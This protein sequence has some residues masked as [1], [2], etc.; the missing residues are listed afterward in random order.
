MQKLQIIRL[1]YVF[2]IPW[3]FALHVSASIESSFYLSFQRWRN[4]STK[5]WAEYKGHMPDLKEFS[6]CHWDKPSSFNDHINSV[7][8]YCFQ[9]FEMDNINCF[10][11]WISLIRSTANRHVKISAE[12]DY[13]S[14][15]LTTF[16]HVSFKAKTI[17]YTHRKWQHYCWLYSSVTGLNILYWNG[18]MVANQTVPAEKRC[19]WEGTKKGTKSAFIIGQEQDSIG[20]GFQ[21]T[22]VF[23]GDVAELN[24]WNYHL[25][26]TIIQTMAECKSLVRGNIKSWERRNLVV[27][28]AEIVPIFEDDLFC[29]PQRRLIIFP[30]RQPLYVAKS[31][32]TIHGGKIVTPYSDKDNREI[33]DIVEK[34]YD[35]CI[36]TKNTEKRNWGKLVWLG[37]KRNDGVWYDAKGNEVIKRINYSNW[38]TPYYWDNVDCAYLQG[39]GTWYYGL[40]G[41]CPLERLCTICSVEDTPVFTFKGL[42]NSS[43]LDYNFYMNVDS[44][45]EIYNYEGYQGEGI[46]GG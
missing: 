42:C 22:Q 18:N 26:Q 12:F 9:I 35:N 11:F 6:I 4:L 21:R 27:N 45:N 15:N 7:W 39:D 25:N 17:P 34:H 43:N 3:Y 8:N 2:L 1:F 40:T 37:L 14:N 10:S 46:M 38:L 23:S 19:I 32:C 28:N 44:K 20:G 41:D 16:G 31:L 5:E 36:R 24:I 29:R 33:M 30:K 13:R